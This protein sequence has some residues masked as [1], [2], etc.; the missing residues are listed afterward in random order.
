MGSSPRPPFFFGLT[1]G[2]HGQHGLLY[3]TG[4]VYAGQLDSAEDFIATDRQALIW[5]EPQPAALL[6]WGQYKV[7]ELLAEWAD[8]R[9]AARVEE[10]QDS[11][12]ELDETIADR[13]ARLRPIEQTEARNVLGA[14]AEMESIKGEPE[15]AAQILDLVLRA[16]EDSGFFALLKALTDIDPAERH[17]ILKRVKF[18]CRQSSCPL[19]CPTL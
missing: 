13:I 3:M 15:R 10:L 8:R 17:E 2:V 9:T 19:R 4:E 14:L 1:G 7:R 11:V 18:S 12:V 16:F 5:N 6:A